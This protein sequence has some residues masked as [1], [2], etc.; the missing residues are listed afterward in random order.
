MPRP[1]EEYFAN[2]AS[3]VGVQPVTGDEIL[4][5]RSATVYRGLFVD[6]T[7]MLYVAGNAV[8]TTIALVDQWTAIGGTLIQGPVADVFTVASNQLTYVGPSQVR[9]ATLR[10]RVSLT[11][12]AGIVQSYEIGIFV[13]DVLLQNGLRVSLNVNE[14]AFVNVEALH[15]LSTGDVLDLRVRSRSGTDAVTLSDVQLVVSG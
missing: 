6:N 2:R 12:A 11:K 4:V 9:A 1:F 5:L 3:L 15:P 8:A 13:N 10:A 14:Y 7:A